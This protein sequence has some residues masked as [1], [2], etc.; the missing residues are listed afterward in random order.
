MPVNDSKNLLTV[1]QLADRLNL[2]VETIRQYTKDNKIP[3]VILSNRQYRYDPA[4]V[5]SA[6]D[7]VGEQIARY[8]GKATFKD[9]LQIPD[10]PGYC[11]EILDG[12]VVKDPTPSSR[13]QI[14]SFRLQRILA[15][16]FEARD[17][18]GVVFGAPMAV[19]LSEV[20]VVQ[21]DLFY[22][23]GS[24]LGIIE[25]NC[26]NGAPEL[27][28]E[29]LSPSSYRRDRLVKLEAYQRAGVPHYWLLDPNER[30]L[31]VFALSGDRYTRVAAG[32]DD[33][34]IA[35]PNFPGLTIVLGGLWF[36]VSEE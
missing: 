34:V 3:F 24:R 23:P 33:E 1:Y 14:A 22:V 11:I 36:N 7:A 16:Y 8:Q 35:I 31:E 9:F 18:L 10:E 17:P 15:E 13:H 12:T 20:D 21:P 25:E 28:V 30:T 2:S 4:K 26:I 19:T 5:L 27:V 29:I 6:L 32:C